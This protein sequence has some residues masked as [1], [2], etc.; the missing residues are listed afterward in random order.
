[1]K[2]INLAFMVE[3][4]RKMKVDFQH[5]AIWFGWKIPL[6]TIGVEHLNPM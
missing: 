6:C 3:L 4:S 5:N 2:K 1:M